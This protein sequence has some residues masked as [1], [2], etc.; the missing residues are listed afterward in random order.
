MAPHK[1]PAYSERM[2]FIW[3]G[4][5]VYFKKVGWHLTKHERDK[6]FLLFHSYLRENSPGYEFVFLETGIPNGPGWKRVDLEWEGYRIFS[7]AA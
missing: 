2:P 1:V 5:L 4:F 7:R 3:K 6:Q